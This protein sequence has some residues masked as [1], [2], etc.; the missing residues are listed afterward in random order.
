MA[1]GTQTPFDGDQRALAEK[2]D[3]LGWGVFF[4]WVG[5]AFLADVG[6]G[7]GLLGVG[8]IALAGQ[9]ARSYFGLP[10]E[11]FGLLVGI[12]FIMWAGWEMFGPPSGAASVPGG[13]MPLLLIALGVGLV[14]VALLRRP[15]R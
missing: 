11:L 3:A 6:W 4:I 1:T 2:M 12:G 14:L 10:V 15:P 9:I 5:I 7:L 13:L 8:V